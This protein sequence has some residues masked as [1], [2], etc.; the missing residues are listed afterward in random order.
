MFFVN[1]YMETFVENLNNNKE[2]LTKKLKE[3]R[4]YDFSPEIDLLDFVV[5]MEQSS[6]SIRMFSMDRDNNEVFKETEDSVLFAGS[7]GIISDVVISHISDEHLDEFYSFYEENEEELAFKEEKAIVEW[8]QSCWKNAA[9]DS[10]N[11]PAYFV[12][13]DSLKSFDLTAWKWIDDNDKWS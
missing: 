7:E 1:K 3:I 12:F 11:L 2:T 4:A 5:F 10:L 9:A 8:F 6:F 13:H